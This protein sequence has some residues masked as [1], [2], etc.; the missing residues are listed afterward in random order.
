MSSPPN[1]NPH[2][3]ANND[4]ETTVSELKA[5]VESFVDERNWHRFH[6]PKNLVMSLAIETAELMEHF[7][8]LTPEQ[9][10]RA[11]EDPETGHAIG[12]EVADCLAYLLAIANKLDIDLATTLK[13]KMI[14]NAEKYPADDNRFSNMDDAD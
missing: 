12:E 13:A 8:W 7:Q 14:R 6:T 1:T 9:S 2:P 11:M 5:V 10:L 4:R 3:P